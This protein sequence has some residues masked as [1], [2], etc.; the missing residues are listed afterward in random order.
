MAGSIAEIFIKADNN[1]AYWELYVLPLGNKTSFFYPSGGCQGLHSCFDMPL[2]PGLKTTSAC[3]GTVNDEKSSD[4]GWTAEMS[5]PVKEIEKTTGISFNSS[6]KW[7]ILVARY[8]YG[9]NLRNKQFSSFPELPAVN[10][11]L[12]EYYAPLQFQTAQEAL[13]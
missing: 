11:H 10:Y 7:K 13:K 2:M 5:I 3:I 9:V 6:N 8:N 4:T 1:P 12:L